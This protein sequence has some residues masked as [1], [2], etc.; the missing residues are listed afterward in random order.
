MSSR[1][2]FTLTLASLL[3][4]RAGSVQVAGAATAAP[5][6]WV[7]GEV[8]PHVWRG[9]KG[10]QGYAF[11]LFQRVTRQAELAAELQ[12]FPWARA[13]LMLQGGQAQAALV[14]S[15]TA[16]RETQFRWL[17]PVG[18]FRFVVATRDADGPVSQDIAGLTGRRVGSMRASAS[19]AMLTA[20]GI[21]T[22][23]E[24]KDYPELL[25]L[26][27]R[28]IV[29]AVIGPEAVMRTLAARPGAGPE[30]VRH[31]VL[32][33][34]RELYAAAGPAMPEAAYQ[35]IVAAYQQVAD[36]GFV[37]QLKKRHPDAFFDD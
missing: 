11:E 26:L 9:E 16:E 6:L 29:D 2:V 12:F 13:L 25:A 27:Q 28:G 1:R 17:F 10:P 22:V 14:I 37:A 23:V 24:G 15:R 4:D 18:N 36:S 30:A 35:R 7:T 8:P 3:A 20:S 21:T 31:T 34:H 19:R 5:A 32:A 33:L